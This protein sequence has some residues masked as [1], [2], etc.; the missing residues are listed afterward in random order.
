M[1]RQT[2]MTPEIEEKMAQKTAKVLAEVGDAGRVAVPKG[3]WDLLGGSVENAFDTDM[4]V[5]ASG[6]P[7]GANIEPTDDQVLFRI[8]TGGLGPI[9]IT[10][11]NIGDVEGRGTSM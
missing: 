8:E 7:V 4:A 5:S 1:A 9:S 2:I 11:P 10:A 3:D 6:I